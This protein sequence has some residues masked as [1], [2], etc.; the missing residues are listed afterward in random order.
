MI[1]TIVLEDTELQDIIDCI[2]GELEC[3]VSHQKALTLPQQAADKK[4]VQDHW[5][6]LFALKEKLSAA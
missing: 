5:K 6:Q 2:D 4:S 1:K 3:N